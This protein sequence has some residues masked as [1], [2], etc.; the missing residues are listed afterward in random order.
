MGKRITSP[1][2][3]TNGNVNIS[4]YT[5]VVYLFENRTTIYHTDIKQRFFK[6]TQKKIERHNIKSL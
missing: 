2:K 4:H 5:T 6:S 3:I 1:T